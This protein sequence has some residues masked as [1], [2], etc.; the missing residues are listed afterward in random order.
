MAIPSATATIP[1]TETSFQRTT[2]PTR[3]FD[4]VGTTEARGPIPDDA[5]RALDWT[6][7]PRSDADPRAMVTAKTIKFW[8]TRIENENQ[9]LRD[10]SLEQEI[11]RI[12]ALVG[13]YREQIQHYHSRQALLHDIRWHGVSP[14]QH[15]NQLHDR[16][17]QSG[18]ASWSSGG[19][20][21]GGMEHHAT[22]SVQ[23]TS[24]IAKHRE[25]ELTAKL[26]TTRS[27]P[28]ENKAQA[29]LIPR[30]K[31][32]GHRVGVCEAEHSWARSPLATP[33]S[34]RA[35]PVESKV[36]APDV[37]YTF[38][39]DQ[40]D[41]E[42]VIDADDHQ[43]LSNEFRIDPTMFYAMI[44]RSIQPSIGSSTIR[45]PTPSPSVAST[46]IIHTCESCYCLAANLLRCSQ[47][48]SVWYC[49]RDCQARHWK[50]HRPWCTTQY[51]QPC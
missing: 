46:D 43:E 48:K 38:G 6:S 44:D 10:A 26:T 32:G 39:I 34:Y 14:K 24:A 22:Q 8:E 40:L 50:T 45:S 18:K 5:A 30:M 19:F 25:I 12:H 13:W 36:K 47:C 51:D 31:N 15:H 20:K 1:T 49:D 33:T 23:P 41:G 2:K 7:F 21:R 11:N 37:D 9:L 17:R 4:D 3:W 42:F 35:C 27:L 29:I 16:D 28:T